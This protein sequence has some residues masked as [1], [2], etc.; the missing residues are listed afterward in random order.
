MLP[1]DNVVIQNISQ[2]LNGDN[3]AKRDRSQEQDIVSFEVKV[4]QSCPTLC[5]SVE[6]STVHGI[7]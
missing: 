3:S 4:A 5:N 7:L 6:F 1:D 2:F